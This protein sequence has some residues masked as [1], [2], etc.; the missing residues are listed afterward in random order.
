MVAAMAC[1]TYLPSAEKYRLRNSYALKIG[2]SVET[3]TLSVSC[4]SMKI[5]L[6]AIIY[7]PAIATA[8]LSV[9]NSQLATPAQ[10]QNTFYPTGSVTV[11]DVTSYITTVT[12]DIMP[13]SPHMPPMPPAPPSPPPLPPY[14]PPPPIRVQCGCLGGKHAFLESST[15]MCVKTTADGTSCRVPSSYSAGGAAICPGDHTLCSGDATAPAD[16]TISSGQGGGNGACTN[17]WTSKKCGRKVR[18]VKCHKKKVARSCQRACKL[19]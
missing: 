12:T 11:E 1:E 5:S 9:L 3:V 19:C 7:D 6:I 10:S 8:A 13:P 2:V 18:K 17:L 14:P 16:L 4:A 15:S